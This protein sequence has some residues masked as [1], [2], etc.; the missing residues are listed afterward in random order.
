M[1]LREA[2]GR[3]DG[4]CQGKRYFTCKAM[5][6]VFVR[7]IN[8]KKI[9]ELGKNDSLSISLSSSSQDSLVA[10][11]TKGSREESIRPKSER[12]SISTKAPDQKKLTSTPNNAARE[13]RFKIGSP[14]TKRKGSPSQ[15]SKLLH[16]STPFSSSSASV[17]SMDDFNLSLIAKQV[18]IILNLFFE[19]CLDSQVLNPQLIESRSFRDA[20][21]DVINDDLTA[22]N[23]SSSSE[24]PNLKQPVKADSDM[25]SLAKETQSLLEEV[26]ADQARSTGMIGKLEEA[27][28]RYIHPT[29]AFLCY[30]YFKFMFVIPCG[31]L[32][33][34]PYLRNLLCNG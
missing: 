29:A 24:S 25:A 17:D 11:S 16:L 2:K 19:I 26:K 8:C 18:N 1:E 9:D 3:H 20:I 4:L 28:V 13:C 15:N 23:A 31:S 14:V 10:E 5:H 21:L 30:S 7:A 27:L 6:G 22:R 34:I 33:S 32:F 12:L